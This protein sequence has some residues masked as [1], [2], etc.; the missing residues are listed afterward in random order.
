MKLYIPF[1]STKNTG[2]GT[3]FYKNIISSLPR[4]NWAVTPHRAGA[5]L[6]LIPSSSAL[7]PQVLEGFKGKVILRIDNLPKDSRNRGTGWKRLKSYAQRADGIVWQS[8][9]SKEYVGWWLLREGIKKPSV[10]IYNGIDISI[11]NLKKRKKVKK[12]RV[13]YTRYGRSETKNWEFAWYWFEMFSRKHSDAELWIVGKF[14]PELIAYNFD[15]F[16]HEKIQYFGIVMEKELIANLMGQCEYALMP[17]IL[18]ACSNSIIE[19][20]CMGLKIIFMPIAREY[21]GGTME[22]VDLFKKKGYNFFSKERMTDEYI[23]FFEQIL[24]K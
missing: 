9:W 22:I 19:A 12:N 8:L 1:S 16:A 24:K 2:G 4:R 11:F 3:S 20:L 5:D 15:F 14:S 18:D 6:I 21:L 7:L 13:F 17:Y 23:D 10:V